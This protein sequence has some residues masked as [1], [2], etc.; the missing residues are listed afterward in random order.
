MGAL[1]PGFE[2]RDDA[3]PEVG[4]HARPS[5][6][7]R[8]KGDGHRPMPVY[9]DHHATTPVDPR[10]FD[11]MR[12][13]FGDVFGNPG[14]R[15]HSF[16]WE[17]EEAVEHARGRVAAFMGASPHEVFF[18]SG[19]TE[20]NQLALWGR[21]GFPPRP[22]GHVVT[23]ATEH[24][25]VLAA[26]RRLVAAGTR[27][28]VLP[29]E[30]DGLLDPS[31][32]EAAIGPDTAVVSAMWAN[33][34]IGVVQPIAR[35]AEICRR[36]GVA[37]H[38]D[39]TQAAGWI[40]IDVRA[41][42]VDLVSLSGHKVHGPKGVGVLYVRGGARATLLDPWMEGGGQE[43]GLR[44]G[45]PNVPGIVGMAEA[46]AI[47]R[48]RRDTDAPRVAALRDALGER[49]LAGIPGATVNGSVARRLPNNLSIS[50]GGI[51]GERLM[52]ALTGVA[53]SNGAAC[54][55]AAR[56]PSHVLEAIGVPADRAQATLRFGLGRGTCPSD[57]RIAADHVIRIVGLL[58]GG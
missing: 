45:T 58:R 32:V 22:G 27:V 18:T 52:S 51:D 2:S 46:C 33:N 44:P 24:S 49:L 56:R 19:A 29:V 50:F 10:V 1:D 11:A 39:A 36:R 15:S 21:V 25:S 8:P 41:V 13:Y 43:G 47:V 55:A 34:E 20:S 30:P 9:L 26:C 42:A 16:G 28:T 23:V 31:R 4:S 6:G 54:S 38:T 3:V 7:L 17:A 48:E 37:F 57:I 14:S 12:P 53:V 5:D 35:I 40:P